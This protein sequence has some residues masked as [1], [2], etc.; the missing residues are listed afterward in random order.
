MKKDNDEDFVE[1]ALK[2]EPQEG[3]IEN[4]GV[5]NLKEI[6]EE[7][8]A[9]IKGFKN[10]GVLIVPEKFIGKISAKIAKNVGVI[11]AYIEGM[12]LYCGKTT[13]SAETLENLEDPVDIIRLENLFLR[14]MFHLRLLKK[15]SRAS[16]TTARHWFQLTDMALS[17]QSAL[18]TRK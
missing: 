2:E 7:E 1:K 9:Q 10:I 17:C 12:R 6:S 8:I 16:A 5:L 15:R 3:I 11:I 14:K 13:I 18:R 4:F